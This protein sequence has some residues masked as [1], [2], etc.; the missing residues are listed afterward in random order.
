VTVPLHG[1]DPHANERNRQMNSSTVTPTA[2]NWNSGPAFTWGQEDGVA[3]VDR[4]GSVYFTLDS[5]DY[6]DYNQ[7]Y[8]SGIR[9]RQQTQASRAAADVAPNNRA[10]RAMQLLASGAVVQ[11]GNG[12]TVHSQN[13]SKVY[14][15]TADSCD[16]PDATYN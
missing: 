1:P 2:V 13:S 7:R 8:D 9:C 15:V 10:G 11:N 3:G 4:R 6:T 5:R 14:H 12:Y 16:C